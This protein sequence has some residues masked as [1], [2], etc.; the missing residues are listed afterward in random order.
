MI[1]AGKLRKD[2]DKNNNK[3]T[4]EQYAFVLKKKEIE[5]IANQI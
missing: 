2:S 4:P 5:A 1:D 3:P